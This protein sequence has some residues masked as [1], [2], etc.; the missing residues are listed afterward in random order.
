[1]RFEAWTLPWSSSSERVIADLPVV[2]NTGRGSVRFNDFGEGSMAL[3]ADYSRIDDVISSTTGRLIRV[4]DGTDI[5]HEWVA[6]RIEESLDGTIINVSGQDLLGFS[7]D[8]AV[9][10]PYDYPD[11]PSKRS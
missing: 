8:K 10:Y 9:V 4:Y 7:F 3:P 5:I 11:N 1:M 6:E 2:E